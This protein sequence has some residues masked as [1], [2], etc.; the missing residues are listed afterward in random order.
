M[1]KRFGLAQ[2]WCWCCL[3]SFRSDNIPLPCWLNIH[4]DWQTHITYNGSV[5]HLLVHGSQPR[6]QARISIERAIRVEEN[7]TDYTSP[8]LATSSVKIGGR[9]L[10]GWTVFG[11]RYSVESDLVQTTGRIADMAPNLRSVQAGGGDRDPGTRPAVALVWLLAYFNFLL[12]FNY[13][14]C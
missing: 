9:I 10:P 2:I 13:F 3:G 4:M 5:R 8:G 1:D 7:Q 11:P 14:C 6:V 12:V